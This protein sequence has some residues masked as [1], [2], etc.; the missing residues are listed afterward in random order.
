MK[1]ESASSIGI[2]QVDTLG[3]MAAHLSKQCLDSVAEICGQQPP[4]P[5]S[6]P[7]V[8]ICN[9]SWHPVPLAWLEL[10]CGVGV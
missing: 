7:I 8:T 3:G 1:N 4:S 5:P 6:H 9:G 2:Q 10:Q